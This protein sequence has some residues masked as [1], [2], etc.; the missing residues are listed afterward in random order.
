MN[1]EELL[2]AAK[3]RE[4]AQDFRNDLRRSHYAAMKNIFDGPAL[5]A[6]MATWDEAHPGKPYIEMAM[7]ELENVVAV[8]RER[9]TT[10]PQ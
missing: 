2:L 6:E 7:R 10:P 4:I 8:M 5:Q 9:T 1:T 3:V